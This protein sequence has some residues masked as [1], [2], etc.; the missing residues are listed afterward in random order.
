[1]II[2]PGDSV[3]TWCYG[4]WQCDKIK[5]PAG[6][7]DLTGRLVLQRSRRLPYLR[8][9]KSKTVGKFGSFWKWQIL[10]ALEAGG[11]LVQLVGGKDGSWFAR[12]AIT[13]GGR[14]RCWWLETLDVTS[15]CCWRL[16]RFTY[17]RISCYTLLF[18][19]HI[20]RPGSGSPSATS[21]VLLLVGVVSTKAFSFHNW[22]SSNF[23]YTLLTVLSRIAPCRILK[24][25]PN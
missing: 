18:F 3:V 19:T 17:I 8:L 24:L 6:N 16:T 22:S 11:E 23:A 15:C 2:V 1:M 12:L 21:V 7:A 4:L 20:F 13:W 5:Q 9:S 14:W 25:N 10:R